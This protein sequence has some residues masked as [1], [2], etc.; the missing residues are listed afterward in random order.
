MLNEAQGVCTRGLG[1]VEVGLWGVGGVVGAESYSVRRAGDAVASGGRGLSG[2][3]ATGHLGNL[4]LVRTLLDPVSLSHS[5][6]RECN[7]LLT[8]AHMTWAQN[9]SCWQDFSKKRKGKQRRSHTELRTD[10]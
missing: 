7:T 2:S 6:S 9:D 4:K 8:P 5:L 1:G 3:A 10:D